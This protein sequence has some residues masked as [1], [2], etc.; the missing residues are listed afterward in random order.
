MLW[1]KFEVSFIH[2]SGKGAKNEEHVYS[3]KLKM[4]F[5]IGV[6]FYTSLLEIVHMQTWV[7]IRTIW[8]NYE[9]RQATKIQINSTKF[10]QWWIKLL[11]KFIIKCFVSGGISFTVVCYQLFRSICLVNVYWFYG[12]LFTFYQISFKYVIY[13]SITSGY[14]WSE[15][16]FH[17][18]SCN[19]KYNYS[20][21]VWL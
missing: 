6:E 9:D 19:F 21:Q 18:C 11:T 4:L 15:H 14:S 20:S 10:N 3:L 13:P 12:K 17:I 8:N 1:T 16:H 7:K 5:Y 2:L